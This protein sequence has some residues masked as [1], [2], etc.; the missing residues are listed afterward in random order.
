LNFARLGLGSEL[1]ED[2]AKRPKNL[3]FDFNAVS[4]MW[5]SF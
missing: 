2:M 5:K 1:E 4:K 3:T